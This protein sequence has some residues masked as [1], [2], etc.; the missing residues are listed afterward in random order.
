MNKIYQIISKIAKKPNKI[1]VVK[2]DN[3]IKVVVEV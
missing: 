1:L 2:I 3:V